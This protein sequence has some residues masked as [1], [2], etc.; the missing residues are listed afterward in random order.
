MGQAVAPS[1]S[2]VLYESES[3]LCFPAI[4]YTAGRL[5]VIFRAAD[6]NAID[7]NA[8]I[9]ICHSD[10]GV[11]DSRGKAMALEHGDE[12]LTVLYEAC[13]RRGSSRIYLVRTPIN[14][15]T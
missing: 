8:R 15:L 2:T 11:L 10:D 12:I 13:G 1:T 3:Y 4:A 9:L 6:G 5:L 7:G 14:S